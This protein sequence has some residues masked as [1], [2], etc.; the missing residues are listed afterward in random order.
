MLVK[1]TKVL[2]K[3]TKVLVK[4]TK[5][6]VKNTKE[7]VKE[8]LVCIQVNNAPT[9]DDCRTPKKPILKSQCPSIFLLYTNHD[10][11]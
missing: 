11:S 2:V 9:H 1:Y 5:V 4:Y 7:S 3:Y 10:L 6:L 8:L